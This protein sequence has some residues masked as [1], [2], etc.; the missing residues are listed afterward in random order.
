MI[1]VQIRFARVFPL[2]TEIRQ[3]YLLIF[4]INSVTDFSL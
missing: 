1:K 3:I 4:L 2:I